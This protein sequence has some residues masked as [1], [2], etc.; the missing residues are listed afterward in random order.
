[1]KKLKVRS[2]ILLV[3]GILAML[4]ATPTYAVEAHFYAATHG[5]SVSFYLIGGQYDIYVYAK[6]PVVGAYAPESRSC[7]CGGNFR[8]CGHPGS[9]VA[10]VGHHY[11]P[12][13]LLPVTGDLGRALCTTS[14]RCACARRSL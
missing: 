13:V 6:R 3:A 9:Q 5:L 11:S 12:L 8:A 1:M 14:L 2:I 4:A 7:I 10:R